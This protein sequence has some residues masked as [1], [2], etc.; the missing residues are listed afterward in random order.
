MYRI[1]SKVDTNSPEFKWPVEVGDLLGATGSNP[2][3]LINITPENAES[4]LPFPLGVGPIAD[5]E[6]QYSTQTLLVAINQNPGSIIAIEPDTGAQGQTFN[7]VPETGTVVPT[8]VALEATENTLYGVQ[9]DS[10]GEQFSLVQITFD[11]IALTA[12]LTD[13]VLFDWLV[14]ALAY[15]SVDKVMYGVASVNGV[16]NLF[17]IDLESFEIKIVGETGFGQF[18]ALDF[19]NDN[20]LFGVD[21]SGNLFEID[22]TTGKAVPI[23]GDPINGVTGLTFVVGEPPDVEPIKTICSS[24]LISSASVSSETNAPKLSRFKRKKNPLHRAIGLFK[25]EGKAGETVTIRLAPEEEESVEAVVEESSVSELENP[26]LN[27]WKGKGRVFLSVRDSIPDVDFRVRKKDQ[28]PLNM[29][30]TLPADGWYYV[31]VI[32][33]LLRFYKTEYCVTLE[34]DIEDSQAWKTFDV[35]WPSDD[36]EEPIELSTP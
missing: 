27:Y 23:I 2:G 32:R 3:S 25:F 7:L 35:A 26:W 34:S 20:F 15:H 6:Y 17:T 30:A 33:P 11:G 10:S 9:V 36:S 19:S 22:H 4:S 14:W 24:T 1:E 8:V 12:T 31:M 16:S 28:L 13:V 21:R 5:I 29:S 18:M